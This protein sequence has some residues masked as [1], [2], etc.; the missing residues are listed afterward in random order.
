MSS[1]KA[2][3]PVY[4]VAALRPQNKPKRMK[5]AGRSASKPIRAAAKTKLAYKT[6]MN[7][8]WAPA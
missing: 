1:G 2:S 3:N 7:P 5:S 4:F 6:S 8:E